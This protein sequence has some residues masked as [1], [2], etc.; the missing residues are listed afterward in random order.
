MSWHRNPFCITGLTLPTGHQW[1]HRTEGQKCSTLMP[2][3]LSAW[4]CW[5]NSDLRCYEV[6][7]C[8]NSIANS[9]ELSQSCT[10]PSKCSTH[11]SQGRPSVK[12]SSRGT[13]P[14]YP[15]PP[16][17]P[18]SWP[19]DYPQR[20]P[21][22]STWTWSLGTPAPAHHDPCRSLW[23]IDGVRRSGGS[24]G[25]ASSCCPITPPSHGWYQVNAGS[26]R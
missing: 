6:Q 12:V 3:L 2:S 8:S 23:S 1:I 26:G 24:E 14:P 11:R 22:V 13:F 21:S 9:L 5:S 7:D 25:A 19:W 18:L 15:W 16:I 4:P 17:V 20:A 10:R